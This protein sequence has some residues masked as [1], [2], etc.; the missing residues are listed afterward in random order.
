MNLREL[1][2]QM[3]PCKHDRD[4]TQSAVVAYIMKICGYDLAQAS[5]TFH[6][7][8]NRRIIVFKRPQYKWQGCSYVAEQTIEQTLADLLRRIDKLEHDN[9][10]LKNK[11]NDHLKQFHENY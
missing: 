5:Q 6:Y 2:C 8:R 4:F 7:L 1:F 9:R 11:Y 10:I 3:R